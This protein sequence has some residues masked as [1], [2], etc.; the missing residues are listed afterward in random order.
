[1][2]RSGQEAELEQQKLLVTLPLDCHMIHHS[3]T[4]RRGYHPLIIGFI[5]KKKKKL[6]LIPNNVQTYKLQP[7]L[8]CVLVQDCAR[9]ERSADTSQ[10]LR[11]SYSNSEPLLALM[12]L[13]WFD[14][15]GGR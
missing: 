9:G 14:L 7:F 5:K 3:L 8:L 11:L 2:K 1:M 10:D 4:R 12:F 15:H 13:F 6:L